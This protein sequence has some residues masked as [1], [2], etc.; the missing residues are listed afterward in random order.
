M[1]S[2]SPE[3]FATWSKRLKASDR[4]A[5][6]ELFRATYPGLHRYAW[7]LVGDE[8]AAHDVVQEAFLR[9]WNR[10][11]ALDPAS[12]LK[13]L[14][15]AAVRNLALNQIRDASRRQALL[16]NVDAPTSQASPEEAATASLLHERMRAWVEELPARR[17]EAFELSRFDG[18]SHGEIAGVLGLTPKTVENHIRL[19]L[20]HLRGRLRELEPDPFKP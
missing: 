2:I 3:Q 16:A 12:S 7:G 19:A 14:L 5:C 17:R 15:F 10:R 6:G 1:R 13:G 9:L 4:E 8:A 20:Q 18:L 11:D